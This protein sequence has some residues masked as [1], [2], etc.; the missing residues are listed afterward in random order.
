[1]IMMLLIILLCLIYVI[2]WI[3][4]STGSVWALA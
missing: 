3:S 2:K 4:N 1:M